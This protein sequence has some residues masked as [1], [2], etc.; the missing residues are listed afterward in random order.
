MDADTRHQ[1]KQ[2]E[3]AQALGKI[4]TLGDRQLIGWIA[5][6]V[7]I[8]ASYAGYRMYTGAKVAALDGGWA[9]LANAGSVFNPLDPSDSDAQLRAII[10]DQSHPTLLSSARLTLAQTLVRAALNDTQRRE[11]LL[12]EAESLLRQI[13]DDPAA[14]GSLAAAA[15]YAIGSVYESLGQFEQAKTSY[16]D[17][18]DNARFAGSP[19]V[20]IAAERRDS[21]DE[22]AKTKVVFEPGDPPPPPKPVVPLG[23]EL[24]FGPPAEPTTQASQPTSADTGGAAPATHS[25]PTDP[26]PPAEQP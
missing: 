4:R 13:I 17:L 19:F 24:P 22:L 26:P 25:Q 8:A 23:P 11:I 16:A 9:Q 1:L 7:V 15:T 6:L 12:E 10:A 2:N 3:L 21:V 20:S 5:V 18:A 14:P